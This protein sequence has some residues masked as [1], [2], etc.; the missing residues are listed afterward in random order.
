MRDLLAHADL[1]GYAGQFVWLE[2]DYD[3][4]QNGAFLTKYGANATPT[5]FIIVPRDGRVAATQTGAMSLPELKQFLDRGAASVLASGQM[6]SDAAIARGDALLAQQPAEAASAYREALRLASAGWP[7]RELAE[8]SLAGALQA[9]G[10]WQQCAETAATTAARMKRGEIFARTVVTGMWCLASTDPPP[11]SEAALR[12]LQPLAEEALSISA[13]VRDHRDALYRTLMGISAARKDNAK[14]AAWGGRWLAELDAIKPRTDEERTALDIARVENIQIYGDPT[15]I[16]PALLLSEQA[17]PHN[18]VA[19]LR[20]AQMEQAASRYGEAIAACDRG[21]Q[22]VTGPLGTAWLLETKADALIG[23]RHP[24]AARR[25]LEEALAAAKTINVKSAREDNI[26]KILGTIKKTE[27]AGK[28][29]WGDTAPR[30]VTSKTRHLVILSLFISLK[31][32]K[33]R[34][35]S[36]TRYRVPRSPSHQHPSNRSF[37]R[38]EAGPD[39][40]GVSSRRDELRSGVNE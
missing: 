35:D 34:G 3:K 37:R 8:A 21:L 6:P 5:F 14:T 28:K 33:I 29:R 30:H 19:S 27:E 15:R 9:S 40:H 2:L 12:K 1:T 22:H 13:T 7:R 38:I 23:Q 16:L 18:Y 36:I 20:L 11:W 24:T 25:V 4:P 17:M 39:S 32:F 10:Q 31:R 26:N